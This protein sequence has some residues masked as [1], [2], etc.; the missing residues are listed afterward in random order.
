LQAF[1]GLQVFQGFQA[2]QSIQAFLLTGVQPRL[3]R[4][5]PSLVVCVSEP[6]V[7]SFSLVYFVPLV[8]G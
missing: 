5:S 4:V 3:R 6:S 2:F 8:L 7:E 1:Q